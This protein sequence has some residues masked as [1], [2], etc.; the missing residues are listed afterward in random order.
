VFGRVFGRS[1]SGLFLQFVPSG[2]AV[3][4]PSVTSILSSSILAIFH[5]PRPPITTK[6]AGTAGPP[7]LTLRLSVCFPITHR[8]MSGHDPP[9]STLLSPTLAPPI[10]PSSEPPS[11]KRFVNHRSIH[12][13]SSQTRVLRISCLGLPLVLL[14][15]PTQRKGPH[16]PFCV[17]SSGFSTPSSPYPRVP[18]TSFPTTW[19]KRE[20]VDDLAQKT[21]VCFRLSFDLGRQ[22]VPLR[23]GANVGTE[24][25]T[26]LAECG[27][28]I[29]VYGNDPQRR[30]A[31]P[32]THQPTN[33]SSAPNEI[34][35][36]PPPATRHPTPATQT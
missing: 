12:H 26:R 25:E 14:H 22:R 1:L 23:L 2:P 11:S 19:Q 32:S 34:Y 29:A 6:H 3:G 5:P 7:L 36:H 18:F 8:L 24:E 28:C 10:Y 15:S 16:R 9:P 13:R 27:S 20:G 21:T 35:S 31:R 30:T 33:P 4:Q 17:V